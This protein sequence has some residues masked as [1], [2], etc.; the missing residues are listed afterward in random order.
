LPG[1]PSPRLTFIGWFRADEAPEV[2]ATALALL[3][4]SRRQA[5][6]R[7]VSRSCVCG[8]TALHKPSELGQAE[9][10]PAGQV[11]DVRHPR[12]RQQVVLAHRP[13]RDART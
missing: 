3:A 12:R 10:A 6:I 9:D 8:R 11:A 4:A 5:A 2:L 13:E 1:L 7:L